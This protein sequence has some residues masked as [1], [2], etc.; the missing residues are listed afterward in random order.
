MKRPSILWFRQ[1]LR[2]EDQPA[3]HAAIARGGPIIPLFIWAP[4]EEK[5]WVPG[6]A[7]RW[8]LYHA[9]NRLKRELTS[10]G[11]S[12]VIR[13][14]SSFENILDIAKRTNAE[15]IFW[16]ERYEP[17][18]IE[19]DL[20]IQAKLEMQGVQVESFNRSLL[21]DPRRVLNRQQKPYQVFTYFWKCCLEMG[22]PTPPIPKQK[23]IVPYPE[24]IPSVSLEEL[25]LLPTIPWDQGFYEWWKP[26]F[27][28]PQNR[29]KK[30]VEEIV[31]KYDQTRDLL[32]IDGTT[33]LSSLLHFGEISPRMIWNAVRKKMGFDKT[34][35]AF[36]RQLGWRE[37]AHYLLYHFPRTSLEP[38]DARFKKMAWEK[39]LEF[40]D[41]WKK[42]MTGYPIVDAGMRQ[43]WQTGWMHNRARMIVGSFLVKDLLIDWRSGARWFWETL[44]DADLANNTLGWQWVAGCGCDAAPFFRIFNPMTQGE[45]FDSQGEYVRR[46]VPELKN[47]PN[48]WIHRPW[49]APEKILSEAGV[50]LGTNYPHPIVDHAE[51]RKKALEVYGRSG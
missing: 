33:Q 41:A 28:T 13:Q 15:A 12:L 26:E 23:A 2:L 37:F 22:E 51:A 4:H 46:W 25:N 49:E 21:F 32:A 9:L 38:L 7:S 6:A 18:S 29:L 8:W 30:A 31:D 14:G 50:V 16:N 10:Y 11:V 47:L 43:L 48:K 1:D 20:L 44:V 34:G 39:N 36:L 45:K 19:R 42:G 35:E 17:S 27:V 40:L 5:E 24:S 3:L